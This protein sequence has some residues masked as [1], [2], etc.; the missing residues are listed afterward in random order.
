MEEFLRYTDL[1]HAIQL[2][3]ANGLTD[4]EIVRALTGSISYGEAR[5]IA[6]RAAPLLEMSVKEIM[7]LRRN[8]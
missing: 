6:Q 4:R 1:A 2:A 5:K 8:D 3:R 7:A